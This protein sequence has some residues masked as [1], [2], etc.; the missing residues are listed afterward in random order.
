MSGR[1]LPNHLEA[2]VSV[3]GSILIDNSVLPKVLEILSRDDFYHLKNKKL[4][5]ICEALFLEN[6]PVDV[7]TV[8]DR[9]HQEEIHDE[10][11]KEYLKMLVE[12]TP[13]SNNVMH[14]A[15]IVK[16]RSFFRSMISVCES[17]TEGCYSCQKEVSDNAVSQIYD[18]ITTH[19]KNDAKPFR[20]L[21]YESYNELSEMVNQKKKFTGLATG[22]WELDER[23]SGL[24]KSDLILI[25]ARPAM[26]KTALALNIAS[27]VA[28]CERKPVLIFSLE[29]SKEQLTKRMIS[30]EAAVD[31]GSIRNANITEQEFVRFMD[32]M[33]RM[34]KAPIFVDDNASVSI[35]GIFSRAKR[36]KLEHGISLIVVDYLQLMN[37]RKSENRQVEIAEISRSLKIL[38]KELDVPVIALSQL[39]RAPESRADNR[40]VLSD[41]RESG[42]IE[43]DADVV[44]FLYRDEYYRS[45]SKEK[46]ICEVHIA[47]HR[48]GDTGSFRLGFLGRYTGFYNLDK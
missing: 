11:D 43:Q 1:D 5:E 45:D 10:I 22:F 40:P 4:F 29:M 26:G 46:G 33:E 12:S 35:T 38:A 16:E 7:V 2:E 41:L 36:M 19:K 9:L 30:Y 48:A 42:A 3:L 15:G 47:K 23:L 39:S 44:M 28:F 24:Q 32:S 18:V 31:S 34:A 17:V 13:S 20:S 25:A 6:V 37:G 14:Y 8:H 27:H 21:I